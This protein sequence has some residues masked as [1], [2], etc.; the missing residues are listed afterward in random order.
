MVFLSLRSSPSIHRAF[1]IPFLLVELTYL[2]RDLPYMFGTTSAACVVILSSYIGASHLRL[3]F[4]LP[5]SPQVTQLRR[6]SL[7]VIAIYR[8]IRFSIGQPPW[9]LN[10]FIS[11]KDLIY[12]IHLRSIMCS[13]Q[14]GSFF[15]FHCQLMVI[16]DWWELWSI[17]TQ[18]LF[19]SFVFVSAFKIF[20]KLRPSSFTHIIEL[21][22]R[23]LHDILGAPQLNILGVMCSYPFKLRRR[24]SLQ[25]AGSSPQVIQR[26][27]NDTSWK[28]P[29][30]Y[31]RLLR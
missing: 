23:D 8:L 3:V 21:I 19:L 18:P 30:Y 4:L 29:A 12:P 25:A 27:R 1:F 22:Y 31:S 2:N 11:Q 13:G 26:R 28:P 15:S 16:Y 5:C 9:K 17:V 10:S 7:H 14:I 24:Y 6:M 20:L